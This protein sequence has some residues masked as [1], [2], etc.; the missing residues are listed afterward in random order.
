MD[1]KIMLIEE[2]LY[3]F[4][5]RGRPKKKGKKLSKK[6]RGI[7]A[8]DAWND[9]EDEEEI[10][11]DELDVDVSDMIDTEAIDIEEDVFDS[12]L[13]KALSNEVKM[14]EFSRRI[15]KFRLKGD[16]GKVLKGVPMAKMGEGNAFIFKLNNG[17]MKKI[18]LRDII[19]E[20]EKIKDNDRAFTINETC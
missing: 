9:V 20:Q 5:K 6:L 15:V 16:L 3:E 4:A 2:S 19:L 8:P 10:D 18:F 7:N 11:P 14:P 1:K 13:Q 17:Q 12:Q